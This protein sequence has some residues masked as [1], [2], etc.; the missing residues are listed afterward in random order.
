[1]KDVKRAG[2]R[3][4]FSVRAEAIERDLAAIRRALRKPLE[5]EIARG[6]MTAPQVSVMRVVVA[7]GD[8]TLRD[9]SHAVSLAHS[10]VSGIIDRLEKRG[11]VARRSDPA[12]GRVSRIFPTEVVTDWVRSNLPALT[13]RPLQAAME[14]AT[15]AERRAIQNS[16]RRLRELLEQQ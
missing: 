13:K 7:S 3:A 10:T 15:E 8:I 12:D 9:L 1:M 11:M 6:E 4:G 5:A 14:R 2:K 16:L